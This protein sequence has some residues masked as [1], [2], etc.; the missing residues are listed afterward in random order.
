MCRSHIR[1][2]G[3]HY[4]KVQESEALV[5]PG[6]GVLSPSVLAP[7][8]LFSAATLVPPLQAIPI[9]LHTHMH[10][11]VTDEGFTTTRQQAEWAGERWTP[12]AGVDS[13]RG[14]RVEVPP[15]SGDP[16]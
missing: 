12:G 4:W 5:S 14:P 9:L 15:R 6:L 7:P 3:P 13:P 16:C 11:F 8:N 1:L 10:P 2:C